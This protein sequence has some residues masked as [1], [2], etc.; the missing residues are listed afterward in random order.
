M[1]SAPLFRQS[2]PGTLNHRQISSIVKRRVSR[3]C[4]SAGESDIWEYFE[5]AVRD[6]QT[7]PDEVMLV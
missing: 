3:S 6:D 5:P 1:S 2:T 7:A 4:A